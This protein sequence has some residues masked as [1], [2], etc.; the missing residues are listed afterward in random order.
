MNPRR[1]AA[2][3][4]R[5]AEGFRRDRRS[6][7]L[8]IVAPLLITALLGWVLR[9]QSAASTRLVIVNTATDPLGPGEVIAD[10]LR[11]AAADVDPIYGLTVADETL[12]TADQGKDRIR[13]GEAD[14]VLV[15]P[16]D[17]RPLS[18]AAPCH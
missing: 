5:I 3:A 11:T 18:R 10:G 16:P 4:R 12:R 9:D 1:I 15:L 8:L 6:L 17:I 14:V 13:V 2:V 7:A